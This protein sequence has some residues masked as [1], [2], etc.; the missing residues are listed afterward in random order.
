[1]LRA[2]WGKKFL[3]QYWP[4]ELYIYIYGY[5]RDYAREEDSLMMIG[6]DRSGLSFGCSVG[7]VRRRKDI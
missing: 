1:M 6:V 3:S 4:I 2:G 5:G 7:Q